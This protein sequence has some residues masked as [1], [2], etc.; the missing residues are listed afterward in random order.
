M[1][2]GGYTVTYDLNTQSGIDAYEHLLTHDALVG[3]YGNDTT[4]APWR[5]FGYPN[6]PVGTPSGVTVTSGTTSYTTDA[7]RKS[8]GEAS[9]TTDVNTTVRP[10][11]SFNSAMGSQGGAC[12]TASTIAAQATTGGLPAYTWSGEIYQ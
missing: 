10:A 2:I 12:S 4:G 7:Q 5:M 3:A 8:A 6:P 11:T 1:K 9:R